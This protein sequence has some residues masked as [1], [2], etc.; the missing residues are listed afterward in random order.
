MEIGVVDVFCGAGGL[1]HG[2]VKEGLPVIAGIDGDATC[3]YAYEHNNNAR[4]IHQLVETVTASEISCLYPQGAIKV[5]VGCAPCQPFSHYTKKLPKGDKWKLLSSFADLAEAVQADVISMENVT[6][7]RSFE[8]GAVYREFVRRLEKS[9]TVT[10]FTVYCPDYGVPQKRRRLVLF[11]S[12]FG[13]IELPTAT[14]TRETYTTV[15]SAI[16]GLPALEAGAVHPTDRLH[17]ARRLTSINRQRIEQSKMGGT[18]RD[19][20]EELRSP[21]HLRASGESYDNVYGRMSWADPAP[22]IT[23]ESFNF[24]SG[25]F[26]HPVQDRAISLREAA[27]LQTF[28]REY[29]FVEPSAKPHFESVGRH[30]GNAVPVELGRVIARSIKTHLEAHCDDLR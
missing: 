17:K 7:L 22:T 13:P 8:K 21:C 29:A 5:L 18:W 15:Q 9:Y 2:F 10:D 26:G 24:G 20:D 1:T 30:I 11:A 28:P 19:W 14:H 3:R 23:T 27:L 25:R 16:G 12:K 6:T 4:F